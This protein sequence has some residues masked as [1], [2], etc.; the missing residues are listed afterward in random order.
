MN[1][2]EILKTL[3]GFQDESLEEAIM[4]AGFDY[5]YKIDNYRIYKT[6]CLTLLYDVNNKSI[7][8][9]YVKK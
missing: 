1:L 7:A 9:Y 4:D 6:G 3:I 2:K 8:K 5:E